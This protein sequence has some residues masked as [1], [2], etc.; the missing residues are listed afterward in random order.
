MT[1]NSSR[2]SAIYIT[3]VAEG[4][5]QPV[6]TIRAIVGEGLEGD[7][8]CTGQGTWSHWPGGGRQVTLI[9][10]EVVSVLEESLGITGAKTTKSTF[11]F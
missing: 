7:R 3:P 4:L 1:I 5:P 6:D 10:A 8:Y 9:E 2:V 11:I